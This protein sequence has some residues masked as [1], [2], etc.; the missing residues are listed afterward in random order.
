VK[1]V[2]TFDSD[3]TLMEKIKESEAVVMVIGSD[4]EKKMIIGR[5]LFRGI[6]FFNRLQGISSTQILNYTWDNSDKPE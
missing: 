1:K 3:E 2:Y 6:I 4:Y 5:D